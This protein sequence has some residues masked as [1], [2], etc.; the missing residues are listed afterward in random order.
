MSTQGAI[1]ENRY[2]HEAFSLGL[3][4]LASGRFAAAAYLIPVAANLLHHA[5]EMFLKGCLVQ[6]VG[7]DRLPKG[8]KGHDLE[9]LWA[10]FRQHVTDATLSRFDS[11]IT[12]LH[13]FEHIRYPENLIREGGALSIGFPSG[14]RSKRTYISGIKT[15]EYQISVADV[16]ALVEELFRVGNV[17]AEFYGL[18]LRQ[19]HASKYFGFRNLNPLLKE[20]SNNALQSDA[21]GARA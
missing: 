11:L 17:N 3:Q 12:E 21:P 19:E 8:R 18:Y 4:Y 1:P 14:A 5:I 2:S 7:F 10:T 9:N 13:K 6:H 15:P 16:D 20:S